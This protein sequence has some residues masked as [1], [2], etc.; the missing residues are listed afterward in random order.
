MTSHYTKSQWLAITAGIGATAGAATLLLADPIT[1]GHWTIDHGIVPLVVGLTIASGHLIGS[2]L[3]AGKPLS[4]IGFVLA[5]LVGTA[6]TTL[7]STGRNAELQETKIAVAEFANTAIADKQA[8]LSRARARYDD[9]MTEADR[10][11]GT[12]CK[13]RCQDWQQR[14]KEV[15]ALVGQLE[16]ELV[17]LGPAKP[18]NAKA[19][20]V[21]E[22]AA[23]LGAD[24]DRVKSLITLLDP[25]AVPFLLEWS[26]IV[27]FGFGFAHRR[28]PANTSPA[29]PVPAIPGIAKPIPGNDPSPSNGGK[30][31]RKSDP[32]IIEF[33]DKFREKHGRAPS[34]FDLKSAFPGIPKSTLYDYAAR[35]RI[36]RTNVVSISRKV[37]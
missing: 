5:F 4:T 25:V 18:V 2:A 19:E 8:E 33:S 23:L 6:V 1:S 22:I 21:A 26:A 24:H 27:A 20:R 28:R 30:R 37:A 34:A 14:A 32:Q 3:R 7:N 15:A 9:A 13:R 31:G 17:N 12:T 11:R 29:I 36:S 35:A 16:K 10:E